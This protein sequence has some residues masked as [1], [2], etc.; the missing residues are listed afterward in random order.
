MKITGVEFENLVK[1]FFEKLFDDIGFVVLDVR[2]QNSG[3]QNGFDLIIEF[4]DSNNIDRQLFVECK[5]YDS[6]LSYT[7]ILKKIFELN[8][9]N[10]TPDG[11]IALSPKVDLSNI[12]HNVHEGLQQS[13][14]FPMEFWT[15]SFKIEEMFALDADL[16]K[17]VYNKN[18]DVTFDRQKRLDSI[19]AKID[20]ILA[21]KDVLQVANIIEIEDAKEE[22]NETKDFKTNLDEKLNSVFDESNEIRLRLHQYRCNYKI[23]LEKLEDL[24]NILRNNILKWQDNLRIKADRLTFQFQSDPDYTPVKFYHDFFIAAENS[25]NTFFSN[26]DLSG[27]DEKLLHGVVLELAAECPLNWKK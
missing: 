12:E 13:F 24:N 15:P 10:Y 6:K 26:H 27:D 25:L 9:S 8:S 17:K 1:P 21:K 20:L 2:N 14:K 23:Y 11:F 4:L 16:F 18:V 5:Y 3:T 22:P 7:E 19:K